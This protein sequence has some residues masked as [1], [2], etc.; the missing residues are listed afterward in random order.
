[1]TVQN[2]RQDSQFGYNGYLSP[3]SHSLVEALG[4]PPPR[5]T[6]SQEATVRRLIAS[7][8]PDASF[9]NQRDELER[10]LLDDTTRSGAPEAAPYHPRHDS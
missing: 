2:R 5:I 10:M 8:F 4:P 1:M 6:P 7:V 9:A 3:S